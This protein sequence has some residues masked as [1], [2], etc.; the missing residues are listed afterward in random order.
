MGTDSVASAQAQK[1]RPGRR[2][3]DG[4]GCP[5]VFMILATSLLMSL[6][7]SA[8][9]CNVGPLRPLPKNPVLPVN[10]QSDQCLDIFHPQVITSLPYLGK[11]HCFS[12]PLPIRLAK[13]LGTDDSHFGP[14]FH[15]LLGVCTDLQ[16]PEDSGRSWQVQLRLGGHGVH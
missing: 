2:Q 8:R 6:T 16:F 9:A 10:L 7:F 13:A 15:S 4:E 14:C 1:Q 3:G 12:P 11:P 5:T